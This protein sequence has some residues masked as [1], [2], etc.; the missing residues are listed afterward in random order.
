MYESLC[1]ES[2]SFHLYVVAFD[3]ECYAYLTTAAFPHITPVT[4]KDFEDNRL[5]NIKTS[6]SVAE[7]CWTCTPSVILYCIT[8]F[9]LQSCTYIDADMIFYNNPEILLD[10]MKDNS[11]LISEH[12]YTRDY[13]Q[14]KIS[15]K[16]C[17][18]FMCF[19]NNDDGINALT[20]WRERCAYA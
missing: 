7:Y 12:R 5:L 13:D 1:R 11:I 19:K 20:W 14:S 10:E 6:R 16:Y 15:G 17:V 18:Q 9:N 4:L 8:K 2:G 3:D